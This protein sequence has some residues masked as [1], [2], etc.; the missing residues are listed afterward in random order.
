MWSGI[1][2]F[3]ENTTD[4]AEAKIVKVDVIDGIRRLTVRCPFCGMEHYHDGGPEKEPLSRFT[5][6]RL[7]RCR[8]REPKQYRL[9]LQDYA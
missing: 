9:V 2:D 4:K 5:G 3:Q 1:S 8:N 6:H 7:S